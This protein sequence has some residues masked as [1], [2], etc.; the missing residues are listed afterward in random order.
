M[1]ILNKSY[2]T[3][4]DSVTGRADPLDIT[5]LT[6]L[7]P[8]GGGALTQIHNVLRLRTTRETPA[9][10]PRNVRNP[11]CEHREKQRILGSYSNGDIA[12]D[13]PKLANGGGCG[14]CWLRVVISYVAQCL[15]QR[16]A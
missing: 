5:V 6:V 7:I 1:K 12:F 13:Y 9:K 3:G 11:Y 14:G 2:S 4:T 15:V 16:M 10:H 8:M